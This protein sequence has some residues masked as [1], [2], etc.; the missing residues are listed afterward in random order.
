MFN[1]VSVTSAASV[2][3]RFWLGSSRIETL[4]AAMTQPV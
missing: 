1:A 4:I 2:F 3:N